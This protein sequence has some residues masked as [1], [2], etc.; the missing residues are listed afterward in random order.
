MGGMVFRNHRA[1]VL[2]VEDG[3]G[4]EGKGRGLWTYPKLRGPELH[5]RESQPDFR[6]ECPFGMPFHGSYSP[7]WACVKLLLVQ[8]AIETF[9][10]EFS[11]TYCRTRWPLDSLASQAGPLRQSRSRQ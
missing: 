10:R 5:C 7:V 9:L 8:R 6:V 1:R 4:F 2:C 11:Y 3:E